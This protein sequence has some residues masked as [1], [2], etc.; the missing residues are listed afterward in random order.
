MM[1]TIK[2]YAFSLFFLFVST[3]FFSFILAFFSQN[4]LITITFNDVFS[5]IL[6]VLLFFITAVILGKKIKRKGLINGIFLSLIYVSINLII[7]FN[8][9]SVYSILKFIG[10]IFLIIVGTI[11]GVNLS[12]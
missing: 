8:F 5:T 3:L 4:N 12:K 7:G 11:I 2:S 6:S 10:K 9:N 1:K